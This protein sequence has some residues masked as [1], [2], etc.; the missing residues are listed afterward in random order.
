MTTRI[1]CAGETL[2]ALPAAGNRSRSARAG[3]FERTNWKCCGGDRFLFQ[4]FDFRRFETKNKKRSTAQSRLHCCIGGHELNSVSFQL[5]KTQK[6]IPPICLNQREG[7]S[8]SFAWW[9]D[10]L[11]SVGCWWARHEILRFDIRGKCATGF[12]RGSSEEE[13]K[14][15]TKWR[16]IIKYLFIFCK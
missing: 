5:K 9:R 16:V 13:M 7:G 2:P 14:E 4:L 15:L 10:S 11:K 8:T 12:K 6:C 3:Q 1:I